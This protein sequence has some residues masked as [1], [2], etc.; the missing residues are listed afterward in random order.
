M[1]VLCHTFACLIAALLILAGSATANSAR[2]S[3]DELLNRL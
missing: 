3:R 1:N 2:L